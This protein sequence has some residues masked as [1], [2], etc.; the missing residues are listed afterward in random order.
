[1]LLLALSVIGLVVY[2]KIGARV[3]I[4]RGTTFT[5]RLAKIGQS[6]NNGN[7]K[8]N[9][10]I[11]E[12]KGSY[13]RERDGFDDADVA[14]VIRLPHDS[15]QD[16]GESD[17]NGGVDESAVQDSGSDDGKGKT[18]IV[19]GNKVRVGKKLEDVIAEEGFIEGLNLPQENRIKELGEGGGGEEE[20]K[21]E[22]N[23][24]TV[25]LDGEEIS[26][27]QNDSQ[28]NPQVVV[29]KERT[30]MKTDKEKHKSR[31]I[32]ISWNR[33]RENGS[34][35]KKDQKNVTSSSVVSLSAST[36]D[37]KAYTHYFFENPQDLKGR[38]LYTRCL[39]KMSLEERNRVH[40]WEEKYRQRES[41]TKGHMNIG[42]KWIAL[43]EYMKGLRREQRLPQVINIGA[44]KSGT[45]AF[46][47]FIAMHP[48]ISHSFG[49]EVHFF[50]KTYEKGLEYYRSRMNFAKPNQLVFEKTPRYLVT[51]SAPGHAKKDLPSNVKF[52]ICIRDPLKRALSDFRHDSTLGIRRAY[53]LNPA[54][55]KNR[56]AISEG[57]RFCSR[58]FDKDGNVNA[59]FD[60]VR[61]SSYVKHFKN[62][63]SHFPRD[64]FL[65][66]DHQRLVD[67]A[68][69]ELHRVEQFLE[70]EPYFNP[71]MFYFDKRRR[72][73][74]V[75]GRPMPCPPRSSPGI[76]PAGQLDPEQERKLR[77]YFRPLN[78]EFVKLV[79]ANNFT[80]VDL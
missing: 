42:R 38:K 77:D 17:G 50:D 35:E 64:K 47:W 20:E 80:W 51:D 16:P 49:N 74:C 13:T 15:A 33:D 67:D 48:Q 19:I 41:L 56:T 63:L 44:K 29:I 5:S 60:S 68:Y 26:K 10:K 25:F 78:Q 18:V 14:G 55:V 40:E 43:S 28:K 53:K 46:G 39:S 73:T 31:I 59:S 45:T 24:E 57:K 21:K 69:H 65:I 9:N 52:I 75:K 2:S 58:A 66:V 71:S 4:I 1:M 76:L 8:Q 3:N 32:K 23:S 6:V 30:G 7:I 79:G 37:R 61:T 12:R 62:W 72:G 36:D 34:P 22:G 54:I 27:P 70:L 11:S